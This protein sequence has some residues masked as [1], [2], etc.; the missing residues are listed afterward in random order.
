MYSTW[1][2]WIHENT[3]QVD[4]PRI[5][6]LVWFGPQS[7]KWTYLHGNL[8]GN[9]WTPTIRNFGQQTA[10]KTPSKS[11]ISWYTT[12]S[13]TFPPW[14][15]T[16]LFYASSRRFL[17]QVRWWRKRQSFIMSPQRIL[18]NGR[19]L[20]RGFIMR[21]HPRLALRRTIYRYRNAKLRPQSAPHIWKTTTKTST[22]HAI[23]TKTNKLRSKIRHHYP[24][25]PGKITR[26][27][28]QEVYTTSSGKFPVL[29]VSYRYDNFTCHKRHRN[30]ES[31]THQIN[32]ENS[33][34]ITW[35]HG[36]APQI[37]HTIL[38]IP[39]DPEHS[40]RRFIL[41]SR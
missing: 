16:S 17:Y 23:R 8:K 32:H 9:V 15:T 39:H 29:C 3:H 14:N 11:R 34:Q 38:R 18:R 20:D 37:H 4:N 22:A 13:W 26:R 25:G 40:L 1:K 30:T 24:W 36:H 10:G 5:Y 2:K 6:W 31:K 12:H 7:K 41:F 33:S 27:L 21:N 19:G 35:L 28:R